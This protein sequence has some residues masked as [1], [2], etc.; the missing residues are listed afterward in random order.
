[1]KILYNW[2][3]EFAELTVAPEDLRS[4][5][6][7]SGTAIEALEQTAAGP[8]LDAEVSSNRADCLGHYGIAREAAVLYGMA[9]KSVDPRPRESS[10]SVSAATRVQIDCPDLCARFTARV[11]RG[12]KVGPSPDW[13]RRRLEALGQASI[14]NVVDATNY[15]MLELGQPMHAYDVDL[16][17]EKRV[18]VRR[19]RAGEKIRTLDGVER[20]LTAEM[21][22][23]ADASRAVGIGGVMGG[24]DTEI[25]SASR[26]ILLEAAWFDPISIRRTSKALGL[27]TEASMRFERGADPEMAELA[28]RRCAELILQM[29]GG[30]VLKGVVD[31]YPGRSEP[32]RIDLTR[33]EFL[34]VMGADVPD[35]EI[36]TILAGLGFS[37]VRSGSGRGAIASPEA[38]WKCRRPS[39][40]GDVTREVDLI[41][42]VAR[43]YGVDKFPPTLPAARLPAARLEH[44][45]AEDRVRELLIGLGYQEIIT[46]P[47]VDEPSDAAFRADGAAPARIANPLAED[48]SVMRTTGAVTMARTLEWNLNH[49]QRNVRLFEFGRTYRWEG[50]QPVETPI[51]TLGATGLAR[52]KGVAETER[53]YAFADLKG[54][55][56]HIGRIAGG[57]SWAPGSPEWLHPARSGKFSLCAGGAPAQLIGHAG[58]LARRICERF[59]LRQD[60]FV[61]ELDLDPL[62]AGYKA[63]RATLRYKPLSCFPAVERDFSLVL[64]DGTSFARIAEA[65][66]DLGI[67]EMSSIDAV[68]LYRGKNLPAGKFALLVRVKF[69]SHEATLTEAQLTAFSSRI[70]AALEKKLGAT[71]RT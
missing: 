23:I 26:N 64:A 14:N 20:T 58:Q 18:V 69:E 17:A 2:L 24:G 27:R 56:D 60:A 13:L 12:V 1:M 39:W 67:P 5:L 40:R 54:D 51:L 16:L 6:S 30:D 63:A 61:A 59:K 29:G 62:C 19:A 44:A 50:A 52:E 15:V 33:K 8:L 71:L 53:A 32:P 7:L 10:E 43:I 55:L 22:V 46:I 57:I 37:P 34:R 11:L 36:E 38:T 31:V 47:I 66:R 70:L 45:E 28:S 4:R 35:A 21:C 68:D 49:G 48:A 65:V 25:R 9:L 3:K 41:E 42:E